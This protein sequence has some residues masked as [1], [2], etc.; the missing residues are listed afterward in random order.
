MASHSSILAWK[1]PWT[2]ESGGLQSMGSQSQT[3]LSHWAQLL[4]IQRN[5]RSNAKGSRSAVLPLCLSR[6]PRAHLFVTLWDKQEQEEESSW[7]SRW[8]LKS[9][10]VK[11]EGRSVWV[12]SGYWTSRS[13]QAEINKAHSWFQ[14]FHPLGFSS[15]TPIR[16][17]TCN[18]TPHFT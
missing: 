8:F 14:L 11:W 10:A 9:Q 13:L 3:W 12:P 6:S 18:H 16:L 1:I 17:P 15:K 4:G 7:D 2:E 5:R